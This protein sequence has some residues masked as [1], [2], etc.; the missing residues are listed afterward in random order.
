M[1]DIRVQKGT[2]RNGGYTIAGNGDRSFEVADG[3]TFV[4]TGATN[5]VSGFG[6]KVF[7]I[8]STVSYA[9]YDQ[10]VSNESYGNLNL[11]SGGS[12]QWSKSLPST[13]MI[14]YGDFTIT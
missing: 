11:T 8:A 12:D 1:G 2:F 14:V 4:L 13:P 5:G 6:I 3:T 7:G 10:K 9:G